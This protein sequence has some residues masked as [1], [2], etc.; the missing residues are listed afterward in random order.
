LAPAEYLPVS[1]E[2]AAGEFNEAE[3]HNTFLEALNAWR[4]VE[5]KGDVKFEGQ[6]PNKG[7]PK[8]YSNSS[9]NN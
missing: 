6:S 3:S 4:G 2:L 7:G 9:T 1:N 8:T 5:A